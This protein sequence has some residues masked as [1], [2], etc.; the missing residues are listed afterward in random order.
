[1]P[2]PSSKKGD[3]AR[4][5][6]SR[7]S[8]PRTLAFDEDAELPVGASARERYPRER[9]LEA[10]QTG[11]ELAHT[12]ISADDA[13][14]ET[15]LDDDPSHTPS[16]HEQ[17]TAADQILNTT[18]A[19]MAGVG[20]GAD[21]AEEAQTDPVGADAAR[22]LKARSQRHARDARFFEPAAAREQAAREQSARQP[23][24]RQR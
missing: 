18:S 23:Q 8:M 4:R 24:D 10:G 6:G 2:G 13:S 16:A 15:L 20:D 21:E 17:R 11:G 19:R 3:G 12:D 1:M 22:R 9:A 5:R 14:P 7:T